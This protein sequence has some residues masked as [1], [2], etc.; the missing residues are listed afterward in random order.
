MANPN[1]GV[2][3][4]P[5]RNPEVSKPILR[6][7]ATV[8]K[9]GASPPPCPRS[10]RRPACRHPQ[11]RKV[12][13]RTFLLKLAVMATLI[14]IFS[15]GVVSTNVTVKQ[16]SAALIALP[17]LLCGG[18]AL[19]AKGRRFEMLVQFFTYA[20]L[21][22]L[23]L[24]AA[25]FSPTLTCQFAIG[26]LLAHG[27]Q[28]AHQ[29][30]HKTGVGKAAADTPIGLV[31]S[32]LTFASFGYYAW[33]HLR[34]HKHNG[35]EQDRESFAYG[36]ALIE[37]S[38]RRKRLLG[39]ALHLSMAGHYLVA[40]SRIVLAVR[41]RLQERLLQDHADMPV[42][43]ARRVEREYQYQALVLFIAVAVS[44]SLR[45][46]ILIDLWLAPVLIGWGPAQSL[47]E[48]TEHWHCDVPNVDVFQNTRSLK[49]GVFA[50]WYTNF[51]NCHVGHHHDMSVPIDMLPAY[52]ALLAETENFRHL[53]ESYPTFYRRFFRYVWNGAP[54]ASVEMEE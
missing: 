19:I 16:S 52:E 10:Q 39:L 18:E 25:Q 43:T 33:N 31:L 41:G 49:A 46:T 34:H 37:S 1:E 38:S 27:T 47:I 50:R 32:G 5:I 4:T 17:A 28:L 40:A 53:E 11:F 6:A 44:V 24:C 14:A 30:L 23:L 2:H 29:A 12:K 26:A 45:T 13:A 9:H 42:A 48:T 22:L 35:S 51:N 54:A 15:V 3:S 20:M 7:A 21:A 8:V 36:Y